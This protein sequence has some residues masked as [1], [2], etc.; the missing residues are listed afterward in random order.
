MV[1]G[2]VIEAFG[3]KH[4]GKLEECNDTINS[5]EI[6]S[7]YYAGRGYSLTAKKEEGKLIVV[8]TGGTPSGRRDGTYF[9]IKLENE[10]FSILKTLQ[11]IIEKYNVSSNNGY[12]LHVDGLPSGIGDQIHVEYESKEKIY[13]I[14]N[15]HNIV[16]D[17]AAKEFYD[18]FHEYVKKYNLDFTSEG[19]NLQLYDDADVEYLQG[20]WNGKHFGKEISVTFEKN[21]V[22]IYVDGKL[23]DDTEYTIIDGD[24]VKNQLKEGKTKAETYFDY[25]YF[26]ALSIFKKKNYFTMIAYFMH[27]SYSTCE[28]MNFNKEKPKE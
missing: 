5:K 27:E 11:E 16:S 10:D 24:V 18:T 23:T 22:K 19:S 26:N 28:L 15:Q 8:A 7:F 20:T 21:N 4:E 14:S 3:A 25:E 13:K 9:R 12:C 2:E 1:G 6:E 17:E